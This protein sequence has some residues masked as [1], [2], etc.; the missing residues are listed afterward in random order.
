[1]IL[2]PDSNLF[3]AQIIP[4]AYSDAA[5]HKLEEW[6]TQNVELVVPTLW[7]YEIVSALRKA[8]TVGLLNQEQAEQGIDAILAFQVKSVVPSTALHRSALR[9]AIQLE[10]TVAYDAAFLALAESLGVEFWTADQRLYRRCQ[11]LNIVWVHSL[12]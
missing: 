7:F 12:V 2:V 4:L 5:R 11:S 1:M 8:M 10:Q 3:I 9:W 6:I